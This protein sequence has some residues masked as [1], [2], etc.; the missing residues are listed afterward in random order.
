MDVRIAPVDD[1]RF[2]PSPAQFLLPAGKKVTVTVSFTPS[3]DLSVDHAQ[4]LVRWKGQNKEGTV[5]GKKNIDLK[6]SFPTP[7]GDESSSLVIKVALI[8]EWSLSGIVPIMACLLLLKLLSTLSTVSPWLYFLIGLLGMYF[9]LYMGH[10]FPF[11]IS[12]CSPSNQN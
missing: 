12:K 7:S 2:K 11:L 3:D 1:K 9:Q 8:L 10:Y 4:L 5:L 6:L